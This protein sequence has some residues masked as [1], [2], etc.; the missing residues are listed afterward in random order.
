[1]WKRTAA[2]LLALLT[3]AVLFSGVL[4]GCSESAV[5]EILDLALELADNGSA[6]NS[7][8]D[9]G[10]GGLTL[11]DPEEPEQAEQPEQAVQPEQPEQPEQPAAT[12]AEG[13]DEPA[14]A[15]EP[16]DDPAPAPEV[17]PEPEP[18]PVPEPE[19][20][21]EPEPEPEPQPQPEPEPEPAID[22]NG[23]YDDKENVALYIHTYGKLPPNYISKKEAEKLG[24]TGGSLERYAPGKCIGGSYFGNYEGVLP[25][26]KG[27]EYHECDIGTLGKSSRGAKRIV[28]SN[29]GLIYYTGDHYETFELLYGEE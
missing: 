7:S 1:M 23:S 26:K 8:K 29:D 14:E 10:D 24:W 12:E 17:T 9:Y 15:A 20:A 27:R 13:Q 25:K 16:A 3:L 4:T 5:G 22:E 28:Y 18:E 2:G 19:P 21:A 6:D 11:N